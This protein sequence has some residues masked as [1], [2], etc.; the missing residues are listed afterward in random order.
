[1]SNGIEARLEHPLPVEERLMDKDVVEDLTREG[2]II[3]VWS[4]PSKRTYVVFVPPE[5]VSFGDKAWQFPGGGTEFF[6]AGRSLGNS[7][8]F[9]V[10]ENECRELTRRRDQVLKSIGRYDTGPYYD[11][12]SDQE[13]YELLSRQS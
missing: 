9:I 2:R 4:T 7:K 13:A 8:L 12:I 1:M 3:S 5:G 10:Y 11:Y 6:Y